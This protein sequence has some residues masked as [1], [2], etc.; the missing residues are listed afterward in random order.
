[1][2]LWV[3]KMLGLKAIFSKDPIDYHKL[4][5][6]DLKAPSPKLFG[7]NKTEE[8]K[9]EGG[10][11]TAIIPRE[12]KEEDK[13]ILYLHGGAFISGPGK[14]HWVKLNKLATVTKSTVWLY[15][16]PKAPENQ[17]EV[18]NHGIDEVYRMASEKF[19][20]SK[21]I[22]MGDSAGAGLVMTLVNRLAA[23]GMGIPGKLILITPVFDLSV[24]NSEIQKIDKID[25]MLSQKGVR[26]ANEMFAGNLDLKDPRISPLYGSFEHFPETLLFIG[27]RDILAPDARIAAEKMRKAKVQLKVVD[28]ERMMH[29][30]PMIPNLK[31]GEI[32][33][34]TIIE[35]INQK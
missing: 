9:V 24:S 25:P 30:W 17:F 29:V 33:L 23:T 4:R 2:T 34:E 22:L 14:H 12:R 19:P 26:S 1:M 35:D 21:I 6:Q 28:E 11:V 15:D 13:L 7:K 10:K 32:A 5:K 8:F 27:G 16:Y 31:D 3:L 18:V 20:S